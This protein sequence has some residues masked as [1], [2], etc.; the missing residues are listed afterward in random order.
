MHEVDIHSFH[1][2]STI[3]P[4]FTHRNAVHIHDISPSYP[5]SCPQIVDNHMRVIY[6]PQSRRRTAQP[7]QPIQTRQPILT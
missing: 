5:Q 4:L 2:L 3:K 7:D 1:S 6:A